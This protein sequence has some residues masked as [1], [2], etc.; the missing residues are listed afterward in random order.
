MNLALQRR[1]Y[2]IAMTVTVGAIVVAMAAAI[3]LFGFLLGWAIWVFVGAILT[4]FASH[5]WLM[6]GLLRDKAGAL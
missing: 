4:S 3:G 6:W 5:G 2:F 1:R